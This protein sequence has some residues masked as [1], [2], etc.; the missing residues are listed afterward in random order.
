MKVRPTPDRLRET[1]F[2]ILMPRI[3]GC[4]FLD[5]Y[6][7]T[8]SVGIEALSRGAKQ[9]ILIERRTEALEVIRNNLQ[10]LGIGKEEAIVLRGAAASALPGLRCDI[11]FLDPP[12]EL[13]NEYGEAM[14]A[15]GTSGCELA[16]AQHHSKLVLDEVYGSFRKTRVVKQGDNSLSFFEPA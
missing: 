15:L 4:I 1:L 10:T 7:G 3:D 5:A 8:A 14:N 13:T 16:I 6:A 12:Y 9:I 11:A 2:S